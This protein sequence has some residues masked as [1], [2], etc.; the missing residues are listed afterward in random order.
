MFLYPDEILIKKV[1]KTTESPF[2]RFKFGYR[3][4]MNRIYLI[5][6]TKEN[7]GVGHSNDVLYLFNY[8]PL[9]DMTQ[10]DEYISM[11]MIDLWTSFAINGY[12]IIFW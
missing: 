7:F 5:F 8:G 9:H 3:G 2:Y 12:V 1:A 11:V 6:N 10:S 4:T